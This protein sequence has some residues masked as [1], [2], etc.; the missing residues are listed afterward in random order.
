MNFDFKFLLLIIAKTVLA[1]F[2]N[3]QINL[4]IMVKNNFQ[5]KIRK[6]KQVKLMFKM[7]QMIIIE[8]EYHPF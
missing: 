2:I 7:M 6:K 3:I 8:N 4:D 5:S 1:K